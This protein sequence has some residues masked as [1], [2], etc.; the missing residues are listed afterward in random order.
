MKKL[1]AL[2]LLLCMVFSCMGAVWA[3]DAQ[4]A[5]FLYV[6]TD[7]ADTN[8]GTIDAPY[9]TLPAAIAA[10]RGIEGTV[11]INLRG[12][13][14]QAS[15]TITLTAEDSDLVIRA[16]QDEKVEFTG[17]NKVPYSAFSKVTD[18]AILNRIIEKNGKDKVMQANLKDLGITDYGVMRPKGFI[19]I[20][21]L[22]FCPS[23]TY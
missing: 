15:E 12:G 13:V 16:Y 23:L 8:N 2:A 7:G 19:T 1:V 10:A 4:E 21:D 17:G 18:T 5:V 3:A 11:V 22:G 9:A 20:D 6:A 14:Y